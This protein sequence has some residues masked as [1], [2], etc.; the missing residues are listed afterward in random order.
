MKSS[1]K[2]KKHQGPQKGQKPLTSFFFTKGGSKADARSYGETTSS[3]QSCPSAKRVRIED[4]KDTGSEVIAIDDS[5]HA[6]PSKSPFFRTGAD[7]TVESARPA[8]RAKVEA[9]VVKV[10]STDEPDVPEENS[11]EETANV[12][13]KAQLRASTIPDRIPAQHLR[14]QVGLPQLLSQ[15]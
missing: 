4:E 8:K 14:F 1:A 11:C 7:T 6:P 13:S 9:V 12:A 3:P 5:P 15:S 2:V 10:L